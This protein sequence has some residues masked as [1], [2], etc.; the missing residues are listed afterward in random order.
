VCKRTPLEEPC[1]IPSRGVLLHTVLD[2]GT[3]NRKPPRGRGFLSINFFSEDIITE[4]YSQRRFLTFS[5]DIVAE[6]N[7][8]RG[9]YYSRLQIGWHRISR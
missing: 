8:F 3:V 4:E 1:T 9:H 6:E 5:K 7:I 2:E